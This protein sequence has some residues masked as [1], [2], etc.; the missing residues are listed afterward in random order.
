MMNESEEFDI[1]RLVSEIADEG[2]SPERMARLNEFLRDRPDLQQHYSRAMALHVLLEF[3]FDLSM[4]QLQP[5]LPRSD[6]QSPRIVPSASDDCVV[7]SARIGK[8]VSAAARKSH[9]LRGYVWL[10]LASATAFVGAFVG[11]N[12]WFSS[13]QSSAMGRLW[14]KIVDRRV[15]VQRPSNDSDDRSP[16]GLVVRDTQSLRLISRVTK[17]ESLT[18]LHLPRCP[19]EDAPGLTLCSGTAWMEKTPA[20][21][22]RGYVVALAPGYQ[23][24]LYVYTDAL[25]QNGLSIVELDN[26]GRMTGDSL[27]FSN[28][29][30]GNPRSTKRRLGCIGNYSES[31]DST[32]TKYY[33]LTGSHRILQPGGAEEVWKLSDFK[34]Q[35]DSDDLMVI[36]WDDS[37]YVQDDRGMVPDR[38]YND[39]RAM[40][41]FSRPDDSSRSLDHTVSY[42]PEPE[43]DLALAEHTENGYSLDVNPGQTLALL[44][45]SSADFQNSLRIVDDA[46]RKIIWESDGT[47]P[48]SSETLSADRGVYVIR[49]FGDTVRRYEIQ[50]RR[51]QALESGGHKWQYNPYQILADGDQS[52]IIGFEDSMT[53]PANV[54]WDDIRVNARW[55]SD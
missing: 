39:V 6:R 16:E 21:R 55:L 26:D 38:D 3:E 35:Y 11:Y 5:V 34:V 48:D 17:T 20:Q 23:L 14:P 52:V 37:G 49:N 1:D 30:K 44:V 18:S 31:N 8:D 19:S 40:M 13:S 10:T 29:E 45:S 33:L 54:D 22:E 28:L 25:Y 36:G 4:Q 7:L 27:S 50:S 46:S 15:D 12:L 2:V 53:V 9:R 41:R 42:S 51:A 43:R 47:Q 32:S 24:D